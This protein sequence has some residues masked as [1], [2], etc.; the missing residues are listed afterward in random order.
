MAPACTGPFCALRQGALILSG[1][2]G[3]VASPPTTP[4][5]PE[6]ELLALQQTFYKAASSIGGFY[7]K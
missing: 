2:R 3:Q 4:T 7:C 1:A 6:G 5:T